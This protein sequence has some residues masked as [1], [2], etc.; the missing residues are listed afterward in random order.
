V[1]PAR[2]ELVKVPREM[3]VAEFNAQF[4]STVPPEQV[5]IANGVDPKTGRFAAGRTAKRVTGGV[6]ASQQK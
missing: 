5:A 1:Q 2:I 3:S 4:P 6:P